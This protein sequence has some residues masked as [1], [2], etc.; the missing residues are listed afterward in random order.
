[1]CAQMID[2]AEVSVSAQVHRHDRRFL[3]IYLLGVA[4]NEIH[5]LFYPMPPRPGSSAKA[6][7]SSTRPQLRRETAAQGAQ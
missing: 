4:Q 7:L 1:M 3:E 2:E 5:A 6:A